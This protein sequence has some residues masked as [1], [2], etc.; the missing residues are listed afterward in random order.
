MAIDGF[1][2]IKG[3][4]LI[5]DTFLF[6]DLNF[7]E[8]HELARLCHRESRGKGDVII[9]E[10]SLGQALYLVEQGEVKVVKGEGKASRE[11]ARLGRGELFGEMSLIENELT[12]ASVICSTDVDLLVIHRREFEGLLAGNQSLALKVYKSFCRMLSE[13]L[14]KTTQEL[15]QLGSTAAA[16]SGYKGASPGKGKSSA[17]RVSKGSNRSRTS[18]KS[19]PGKRARARSGGGK[20]K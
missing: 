3:S 17:G 4:E 10:N 13:R 6:K 11:I 2:E 9:E 20:R 18:S 1:E 19:K 7:T 5:Q 8:S 15:S 16:G 14:R 12:S